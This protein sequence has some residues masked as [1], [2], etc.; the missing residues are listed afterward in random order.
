[1]ATVT[2]SLQGIADIEAPSVPI[3]NDAELVF[4]GI[5]LLLLLAAGCYR[6]W[7]RYFSRRGRARRSLSRIRTSVDKDN[8]NAKGNNKDNAVNSQLA[9][10]Q[11]A[12]IMRQ[13]L[14][15]K[16]ISS[17]IHL[18]FTIPALKIRWQQFEKKLSSARYAPV[19][20]NQDE[21]V[22]LI[23]DAQYWLQ[24]WPPT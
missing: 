19:H 18:P 15:L 2:G 1:M 20:L 11:I 22:D 13:G 10:F 16:Q 12:D 14:G 4:A 9:A 17:H 7:Q 21:L 6:F 5:I 24:K 3:T 8:G 23:D